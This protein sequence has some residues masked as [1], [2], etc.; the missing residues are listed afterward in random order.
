MRV[1]RDVVTHSIIW[2]LKKKK[3]EGNNRRCY[4]LRT[5]RPGHLSESVILCYNGCGGFY[6]RVSYIIWPGCATAGENV[7]EYYHFRDSNIPVGGHLR[8]PELF[9]RSEPAPPDSSYARVYTIII[10]YVHVI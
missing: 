1:P 10:I 3:I 4:I 7:E 5:A 8:S 9:Q 2:S 6:V